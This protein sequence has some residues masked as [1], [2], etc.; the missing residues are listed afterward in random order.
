MSPKVQDPVCGMQIDLANAAATSKY[1][2]QTYFF[3]SLDCKKTFDAEPQK[4]MGKTEQ[5]TS[6]S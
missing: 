4:Y 5:S 6:Q 2:G 3:C 1:R